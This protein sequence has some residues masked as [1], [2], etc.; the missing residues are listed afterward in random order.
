MIAF[1]YTKFDLVWIKGSGVKCGA[2]SPPRLERV[3]E[4][5]A[6]IGLISTE[7]LRLLE[8]LVVPREMKTVKFSTKK[9]TTL[10]ILDIVR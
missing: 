7:S 3:F 5:Q 6:W 9:S 8:I 2:D 1:A 10:K 4:I